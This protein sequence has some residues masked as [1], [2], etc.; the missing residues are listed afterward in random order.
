M[1]TVILQYCIENYNIVHKKTA[2]S[3]E[4]AHCSFFAVYL[5]YF[6]HHMLKSAYSTEVCGSD[7]FSEAAYLFSSL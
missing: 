3:K 7:D 4:C 1:K 5:L 2:M 6:L